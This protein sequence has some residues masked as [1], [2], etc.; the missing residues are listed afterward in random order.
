[1]YVILNQDRN[2]VNHSVTCSFK[3]LKF[4]RLRGAICYRLTSHIT[5]DANIAFDMFQKSGNIFRA[6]FNLNVTIIYT[7]LSYPKFVYTPTVKYQREV[8]MFI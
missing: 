3:K 2:P 8:E 5:Y 7:I 6:D 1:M 4:S